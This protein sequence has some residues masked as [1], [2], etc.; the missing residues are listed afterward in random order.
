MQ[1]TLDRF[2]KSETAAKLARWDKG[3]RFARIAESALDFA[4]HELFAALWTV[5]FTGVVGG[6]GKELI[7]LLQGEFWGQVFLLSLVSINLLALVIFI[8]FPK[9]ETEETVK[10]L[11][12][13]VYQMH[14]VLMTLDEERYPA[15]ARIG[16]VKDE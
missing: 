2:L 6:L 3:G 13:M 14:G 9:S 12:E 8:F 15:D 16:W 7:T 11:Y 4:E 1:K 10:E 5:I